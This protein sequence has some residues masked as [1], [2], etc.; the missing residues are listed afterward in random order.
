MKDAYIGAK[1][2]A[3]EWEIDNVYLNSGY[4]INYYSVSLVL[5]SIFQAHN[6][7]ANIWT[8]LIGALTFLGLLV[9]ICISFTP[10]VFKTNTS[11]LNQGIDQ[12]LVKGNEWNVDYKSEVGQL[13]GDI[14]MS[15][16]TSSGNHHMKKYQMENSDTNHYTPKCSKCHATMRDL[17]GTQDLQKYIL[18]FKS[19]LIYFKKD[20]D[21]NATD[22]YRKQFGL[23]F[24]MLITSF[25]KLEHSKA[26]ETKL[27]LTYTKLEELVSKFSDTLLSL[28]KE[29][30]SLHQSFLTAEK[31]LEVYPIW[32]FILTAICCLGMST[33]YHL[34]YPILKRVCKALLKLDHAGISIMN[35]GSA[36]VIFYYYFYC[37][38]LLMTFYSV[39][40]GL[41]CLVVFG[42]SMGDTL[43]RPRNSHWKAVMHLSLAL[44]NIIPLTHIV[45][46]ALVSN[47][48]PEYLPFNSC[49]SVAL[50]I[51]IIYML[52]LIIYV[53]KVPERFFPNKYDICCNSHAI[54]HCFVF[55][56]AVGH[57]LNV[58]MMYQTRLN[59][60]CIN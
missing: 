49:F 56:A 8:H 37:D 28:I 36:F 9:Y 55:A 24:D 1:E 14:D 12:C 27:N 3:A 2:D 4:R 57:Y 5:R 13:Y 41:N 17:K 51:I 23:R 33:T 11:L 15:D 45:V 44:S 26:P 39:F 38:V 46:R 43:H 29:I 47:H 32:I 31:T 7:L 20:I 6:E 52:G 53:T 59:H 54:W 42:L 10:M 50:L 48:N 22:Y 25:G 19:L 40:I 34:F 30:K 18:D 35:F 21:Q 60:V 58:L 16:N